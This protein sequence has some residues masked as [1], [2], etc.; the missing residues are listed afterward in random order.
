MPKPHPSKTTVH[1]CSVA[2]AMLYGYHIL[3]LLQ[4]PWTQDNVKSGTLRRKIRE[5]KAWYRSQAFLAHEKLRG[6]KAA[7]ALQRLLAG[8][9]NSDKPVFA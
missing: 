4:H 6:R 7:V 3:C 1:A 9:S 5:R 2:T 8:C